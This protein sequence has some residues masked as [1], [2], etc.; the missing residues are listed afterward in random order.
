VYFREGSHLSYP[1]EQLLC[2][3]RHNYY[4]RTHIV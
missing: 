2:Q 4:F 3:R 1:V